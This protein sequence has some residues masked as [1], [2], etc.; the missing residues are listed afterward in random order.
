MRCLGL[1]TLIA[2]LGCGSDLPSSPLDEEVLPG[3]SA[4]EKGKSDEI[5]ERAK[6][7]FGQTSGVVAKT[8]KVEIVSSCQGKWIVP[9]TATT[10]AID[11]PR[12]WFV[13]IDEK[14]PSDLKLIRPE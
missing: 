1:V 13:E 4:V 10:E 14:N 9:I 11:T 6:S 7:F 12:T 2:L 5:K 3:C 8:L